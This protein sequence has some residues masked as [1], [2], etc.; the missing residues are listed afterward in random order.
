MKT[1]EQ[2]AIEYANENTALGLSKEL[3][4]RAY[5]AGATEA[6]PG[7]WRSVEDELPK[8]HEEVVVIFPCPY[9]PSITENTVAYW[10]GKDWYTIDGDNIWPTYWMPIPEP[11]K[12]ES[13]V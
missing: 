7:L 5:I 9:R 3:A 11:P 13:H 2:K 4:I 6:L 8:E 10:D 1:I 12:P